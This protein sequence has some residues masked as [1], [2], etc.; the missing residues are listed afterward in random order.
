LETSTV[1]EIEENE[2][3]FDVTIFKL[4]D[5]KHIKNDVVWLKYKVTERLQKAKL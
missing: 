1:F 5:I 4:E 3:K 2:R